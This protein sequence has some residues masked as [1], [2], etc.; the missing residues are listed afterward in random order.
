M[1]QLQAARSTLVT[2]GIIGATGL[3]L[4]VIGGVQLFR[5]DRGGN[6]LPPPPSLRDL[7]AGRL[8]T[9]PA[10][11]SKRRV[12]PLVIAGPV[13]MIGAV[14]YLFTAN[15]HINKAINIYNQ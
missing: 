7:Q 9:E 5:Q 8:P 15:G 2:G 10:H 6:N 13:I 3:L 14:V 11:N 1:R 4:T 12:P